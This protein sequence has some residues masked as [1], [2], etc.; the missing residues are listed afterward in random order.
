MLLKS[1]KKF[2]L[3]LIAQQKYDDVIREKR[4]FE[5]TAKNRFTML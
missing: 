4:P 5:G 3:K 1:K 2:Q